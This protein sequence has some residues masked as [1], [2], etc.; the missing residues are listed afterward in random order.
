MAEAFK[1]FVNK[2]L[3]G[4]DLASDNQTITL[5]TNESNKQAIVRGIDV[6]LD[7]KITKDKAKFFIGNQPVMETFESASGSLLVDSGQSLTVKLNKAIASQT[8]TVLPL[9]HQGYDSSD[10]TSYTY[11][12]YNYTIADANADFNPVG[13]IP[14]FVKGTAYNPTG[15]GSSSLGTSHHGQLWRADDGHYWGWFMD[16]N[17]TSRIVYSSDGSSFS[18]VD[19]TSYS[20]PAIDF[21]NKR[22]YRKSSSTLSYWDMTTTSSSSTNV[23][24]N[25]HSTNTT[26]QTGAILPNVE[27]GGDVYYFHNYSG[28]SHYGYVKKVGQSGNTNSY[29]GSYNANLSSGPKIVAAYNSA[30]E[31]VYNFQVRTRD[32]TGSAIGILF[33]VPI[34]LINNLTGDGQISG[35]D[36]GGTNTSLYTKIHH[37]ANIAN[38]LGSNVH[39]VSSSWD[40]KHLGGP[41]VSFPINSSQVRI[42]KCE[43]NQLTLVEDV[44]IPFAHSNRNS[45]NS[46]FLVGRGPITET[47]YT[48]ADIDITSQVRVTGVELS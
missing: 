35:Q 1:E 20:G 28:S 25:M 24:G 45:A 36:V 11:T 39:S 8:V 17:S 6:A 43:N 26:Y 9:S 5:F 44:N 42:A 37:N 19:T 3:S 46:S 12:E 14:G 47:T 15:F 22:I 41:Y 33:V 23:S 2:A 16:D 27:A 7:S 31:K 13:V 21:H 38:V 30:E 32:W 4:S 10:N 34:G 48:A 29:F 40:F 18:N